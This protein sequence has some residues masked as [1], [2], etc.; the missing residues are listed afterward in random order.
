MATAIV[1]GLL[2]STV[3]SLVFLPAIC[4]GL[5]ALHSWPNR[6]FQFLVHWLGRYAV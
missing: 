2:F 5:D 1:G 3:I 4:T 6:V